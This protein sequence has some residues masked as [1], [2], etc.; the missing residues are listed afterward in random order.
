MKRIFLLS[1]VLSFMFPAFSQTWTT[2]P[3]DSFVSVK[4]PFIKNVKKDKHFDLVTETSFGTILIFKTADDVKVTPDI[5]RDK[6]LNKYYKKYI[7]IVSKSSPKGKI[8]D[9][10][11]ALIGKLKVKDFTLE[12]DTG[13]GVLYRNFRILHAN[14]N[15]Y[16]FEFLYKDVHKEYAVP[17]RDQ[18][19]K[20]IT[21]NDVLEKKDQYTSAEIN[22][23]NKSNSYKIWYIGGGVVVLLVILFFVFRPNKVVS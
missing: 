14:N 8:L 12:T 20:S 3:I 19:F 2:V 13:T 18:F 16:T 5:E 10:K 17:E 22:D 15:T 11:D 4:V 21:V 1:L 9:T 23:G 6:H 7:E